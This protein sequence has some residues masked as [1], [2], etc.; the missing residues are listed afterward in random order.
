MHR[1]RAFTRHQVRIE[2]KILSPDLVSCIECVVMDVSRGGALVSVRSAATVPD[3]V[4]LWQAKTETILECEVRWRKFG[5]IGLKFIEQ[6][7]DELN[8]L[9]EACVPA[10]Q[11]MAPQSVRRVA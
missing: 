1:E 11:S 3:R 5:L 7:T 10:A 6:D 9:I 4:Y 8:T 2:A